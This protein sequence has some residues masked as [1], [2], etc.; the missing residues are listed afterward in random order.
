MPISE[1]ENNLTATKWKGMFVPALRKVRHCAENSTLHSTFG[2][3]GGDI[4]I[5]YFPQPVRRSNLGSLN[6]NGGIQRTQ[7]LA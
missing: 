1:Y 5:D 6:N 3:K 7:V 2:E 4:P